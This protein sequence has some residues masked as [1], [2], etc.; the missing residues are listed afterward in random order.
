MQTFAAGFRK[1]SFNLENN[2]VNALIVV[3]NGCPLNPQFCY[4]FYFKLVVP[5]HQAAVVSGTHFPALNLVPATESQLAWAM[6]WLCRVSLIRFFPGSVPRF[7]PAFHLLGF[8]G[9][10]I[11]FSLRVTSENFLARCDTF[12]MW[13][14]LYYCHFTIFAAKLTGQ[15]Y[16]SVEGVDEHIATV[17]P[18]WY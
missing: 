14:S 13:D 2:L 9:P 7:L 12:I 10:F 6:T 4:R 18:T 16:V 15:E 8:V 17:I 1:P 3:R 11:L 5:C